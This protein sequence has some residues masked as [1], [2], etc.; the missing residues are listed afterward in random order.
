MA[1]NRASSQ[2]P[3]DHFTVSS[4][5]PQQVTSYSTSILQPLADGSIP[6]DPL[7]KVMPLV[8]NFGR[9][10]PELRVQ[11]HQFIYTGYEGVVTRR[12]VIIEGPT[13]LGKTRACLASVL[14]YL[15]S[16]PEARLI[17]TS[18]TVTQ[19]CNV[20]EE[21]SEILLASKSALSTIN[22]TIHIGAEK[23]KNEYTNC[24]TRKLNLDNR[25]KNLSQEQSDISSRNCKECKYYRGL[26]SNSYKLSSATCLD[27]HELQRI[28][29]SGNCP[30]GA[31][32][33]VSNE[34]RIVVA[35]HSYLSDL[36]WIKKYFGS[37]EKCVIVIDEAHSFLS[38]AADEPFLSI[39]VGQSS[40]SVNRIGDN[41]PISSIL[42]QLNTSH[43][44]DNDLIKSVKESGKAVLHKIQI[45]LSKCQS[46][47]SLK[48]ELIS[49]DLFE[50]I[51]NL[52]P[53]IENFLNEVIHQCDHLLSR[54]DTK[55]F[56]LS[57]ENLSQLFILLRECI[58]SPIEFFMR[59]KPSEPSAKIYALHPKTKLRMR[60][61]GSR[62]V[63]FSS[64]TI[65]PV[66][67]VADM[68]GYSTALKIKLN[69]IFS[70]ENYKHF[71]IA[72]INTSLKDEFRDNER[73][74]RQGIQSLSNERVLSLRDRDIL[75]Q[76]F[77][78][79]FRPARKKNIGIFCNNILM[80]QQVAELLRD[81]SE[82]LGIIVIGFITSKDSIYSNT[83]QWLRE[84][85]EFIW[86]SILGNQGVINFSDEAVGQL[87]KDIGKKEHKEKLNRTVVLCAVQGGTLAE[88]VDYRGDAMEMVI[89]I[90]LPYPPPS[91]EILG[92]IKA[93][94]WNMF[95]ED[96]RQK[97]E[98][99]AF[100][101]AAF[102]KLAQSIG[103]AH[104]TPRDR[105]VVIMVDER[106]LGIKNTSSKNNSYEFLNLRN[107]AKNLELLQKPVQGFSKNIVIE[108]IQSSNR[109]KI[110][111]H[112]KG[113]NKNWAGVS[114][115]DFISF[116]DMEKQIREFYDTKNIQDT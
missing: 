109:A 93:D 103:R 43:K 113:K 10:K 38:A 53:K 21:I 8:F 59:Y 51:S 49:E 63:L 95:Y 105:A 71:F 30:V 64:A 98:E 88:G 60:L 27:K 100:K 34:A 86:R 18:A 62:S 22:A 112:I 76:L 25:N 15:L 40:K 24:F 92:K 81:K 90:G 39:S 97:A 28:K 94:Y 114:D 2:L 78:H 80:V 17:Y 116:A 13:G 87:F 6:L 45:A 20:A 115:A 69:H 3:T 55:F 74:Q 106:L 91:E 56:H 73:S 35:P 85:H 65:S 54:N 79:A 50:F 96:G 70:E 33:G 111:E 89:T 83:K 14:P 67:D 107:T 9:R 48:D 82:E 75:T 31:M 12:N 68:L 47:Q 101:Q 104:R 57:A 41:Y 58:R 5:S 1:T 16:D 4:S 46:G 26:R 11:Q 29:E 72:G 77:E 84:N 44:S 36:F 66:T 108:H 42:E 52:D 110:N 61:G 102:R 32:R 37:L 7:Q 99:L 19:V 23:V